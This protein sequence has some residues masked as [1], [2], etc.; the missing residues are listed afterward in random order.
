MSEKKRRF[1]LDSIVGF[2]VELTAKRSETKNP[3]KGAKMFNPEQM[4][5]AVETAIKDAP[6]SI[7][8]VYHL[9]FFEKHIQ[10]L[11]SNHTDKAH[12]VF[13]SSTLL[14]MKTGFT[15]IEWKFLQTKI[16]NFMKGDPQ[17]QTAQKP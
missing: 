16:S 7:I 11:P 1:S 15:S 2:N 9:C 17:C 10:C 8:S 14:K 3:Q 12:T 13:Y 5:N 6:I 4:L